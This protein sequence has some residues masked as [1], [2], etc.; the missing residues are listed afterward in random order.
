MDCC[1]TRSCQAVQGPEL[2]LQEMLI[3][4]RK[5]L[6]GELETLQDVPSQCTPKPTR[7]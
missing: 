5:E 3:T 2:E 1:W 7:S 4:A 6:K